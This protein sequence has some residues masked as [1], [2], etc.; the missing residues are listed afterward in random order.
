[1]HLGPLGLQGFF[2]AGIVAL[3]TMTEII[4]CVV[5][6]AGIVDQ[7]IAFCQLQDL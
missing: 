3:G 6:V 7:G 1:M 4:C 5:L 2:V